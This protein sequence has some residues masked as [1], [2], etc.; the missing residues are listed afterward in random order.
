VLRLGSHAQTI[1]YGHQIQ[2]SFK[3]CSTE[4]C[5]GEY[6]QDR[7]GG[8]MTGKV[9]SLY[10][11]FVEI[12]ATLLLISYPTLMLVVK[13]GMNGVFL[14]MLLLAMLVWVFRP[15]GLN[16]VIWQREWTAYV[17]AMVAMP[18]AIFIS[19]TFHQNY[20]AHPYDAAS[21][22]F[23]AIPVF[24][25]LQRL[26]LNIFTVLQFAFPAAAITGL[27]LARDYDSDGRLYISTMDKIHFGDFEMIL[28]VLSLFSLNWFGR[29]KMLLR[30]FKVSGFI[31]GLAAS[32]AS[33][34]RGGWLAMPMFIAFF[35]YFKSGRISLRL[36][37]FTL[38]LVMLTFTLLYSFNKQFSERVDQSV[39][40]ITAFNQNDNRFSSLNNRQKLFKAAIEM[41]LHNPII[42]V[43]P[44][45]YALGM[46][47][48]VEAGKLTALDAV[49][50]RAEVHN[51]ILSK[52]AG[53]GVFGLLAILAI[54]IVPFRLFWRATKS[55]WAQ[56]RRAGILGLTFVS[57]FFVFGLTVEILN[58]TMA[59]AFY[60][61]TVAVLLAAC[62][63]VHYDERVVQR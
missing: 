10:N 12:A 57:G 34:S 45:G 51:D 43:G 35:I 19:Q 16:A 32:L 42:G 29:D 2:A 25:L 40:E 62:Y 31:A 6:G 53:M 52:A 50:G 23:L 15:I 26:R 54:Y 21:R 3:A 13:G 60:S 46:Q 38:T 11:S 18:V 33:D 1:K 37:V 22:Y 49:Y 41:F 48:M 39:A 17:A 4:N 7:K 5:K 27:L 55:S 47:S 36:I 59:T 9:K 30:M 24:M 61:F 58:L 56:V 44:E 14:L 28:G 20:T 8:G 63:N